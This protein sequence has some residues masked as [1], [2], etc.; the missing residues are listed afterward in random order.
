MQ[1]RV[2]GKTGY[3]GGIGGEERSL[4][5]KSTFVHTYIKAQDT[6]LLPT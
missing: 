3:E 2:K 6:P 1:V 5:M 4:I